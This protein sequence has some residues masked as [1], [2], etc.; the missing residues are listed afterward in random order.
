MSL[1]AKRPAGLLLVLPHPDDACFS[2]GGL[3]ARSIAEGRRVDLVVCT[4]GEEGEVHD[5][6]LDA[7]EARPRMREIRAAERQGEAV[8]DRGRHRAAE[9][10][11]QVHIS[12]SLV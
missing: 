2:T 4:G 7:D 1:E 3:I 6:S 12:R 9:C 10:S 5:P 11:S 8:A